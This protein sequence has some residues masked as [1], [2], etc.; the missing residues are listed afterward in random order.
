MSHFSAGSIET[1][2]GIWNLWRAIKKNKPRKRK[3]RGQLEVIRL[4][5]EIIGDG[6]K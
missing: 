1:G 3:L 2:V 6:Y 4:E 5:V